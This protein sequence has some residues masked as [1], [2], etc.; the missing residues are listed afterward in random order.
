MLA[1]RVESDRR[2]ALR[3]DR[4]TIHYLDGRT[5]RRLLSSIA[6]M[7]TV[8]DRDFR[9]TLPEEQDVDRILVGLIGTSERDRVKVN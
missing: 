3:D 9:I 5:E 8:L 6:D 7:K 1:A 4:F 2:Y